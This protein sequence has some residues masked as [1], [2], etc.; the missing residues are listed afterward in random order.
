MNANENIVPDSPQPVS[1]SS[2]LEL[3]WKSLKGK[4]MLV[5]GSLF[6]ALA[7]QSAASFIPI[8]QMFAGLLL[9]PLTVG[10]MAIFLCTVRGGQ[11]A[12]DQ[13]FDPF[14]QYFR[15]LWGYLRV[16]IFVFL[17]TLLLIIPGIIAAIR[18]SQTF[19]IM[20]DNPD[21]YAKEA[22][23]E[24]CR[25]M[26]GHK[27]QWFGYSLL[28]SLIFLAVVLLTLGIGLIWLIPLS[29][30]FQAAFYESIRPRD[31]QVEE[32]A[33]PAMLQE[34]EATDNVENSTEAADDSSTEKEN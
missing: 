5:I 25:I 24:S 28:F 2:V 23:T 31:D 7:I 14:R 11:P 30:A 18:Y 16:A 19:F 8:A 26:K 33:E 34:A 15:Y 17:W 6:I 29:W 9:F 20:L 27:L 3:A 10:L 13:L 21:C 22:M 4:W 12:L 32:S 1:F